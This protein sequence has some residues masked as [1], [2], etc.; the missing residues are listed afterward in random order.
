MRLRLLPRSGAVPVV[1][2]PDLQAYELL[3]P[4]A[5]PGVEG[6]IIL[7]GWEIDHS[8]YS[9]VRQ[10]LSTTASTPTAQDRTLGHDLAFNIVAERR[11]LNPFV[12]SVLPVIVILCL[13]FG[14]IIIGSKESKKV[15]ATG[16]KATD[17]LRASATLLFPAL[18]AQVNMRSKIDANQIIY[19]EYLYFVLYLAILGVAANAVLFTLKTDGF[20]QVRD[21]LIPKLIFWPIILGAC[22][23]VSLVFLY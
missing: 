10:S 20:A 9:Y 2:V 13:L 6:T 23:G 11:F 7:P 18:I 5:L 21:N 16:F 3:V 1:L 8:Y 19:I 17:I 15:A 12:S 4:A 22:F 14:L